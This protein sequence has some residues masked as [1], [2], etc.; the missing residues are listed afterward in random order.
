MVTAI[1]WVL[2]GTDEGADT[3]AGPATPTPQAQLSSMLPGGYAADGCRSVDPLAN[4]SATVTCDRNTDAGGPV[5]AT[6]G[7]ASDSAALTA[8]FTALQQ[9]SISAECP[10]HLRSPVP[11]RRSATPQVVGGAIYCGIQQNQPVLAWTDEA[12]LLLHEVRG[13]AQVSLSDL[14]NWWFA[15]A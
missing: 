2:N 7:L 1:I 13:N 4:L 8:A 5:S 15:H 12:Q 6:Y 11:W 14:F 9:R 10:G 3:T